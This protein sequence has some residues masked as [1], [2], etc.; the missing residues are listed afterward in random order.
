MSNRG[1]AYVLATALYARDRSKSFLA[2]CEDVYDAVN[3]LGFGS[4]ERKA[5]LYAQLVDRLTDNMTF[6]RVVD[7]IEA[8]M[9]NTDREVAR[10]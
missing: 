10:G 7:T 9:N 1:N 4:D 3:V 6:S 5:D 8:A 2:I